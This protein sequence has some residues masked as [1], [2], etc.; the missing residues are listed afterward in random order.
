MKLLIKYGKRLAWTILSLIICLAIITTLYYFNIISSN[1]FKILQI[2]TLLIIILINSFIL[3]KSSDKKGFLEGIKFGGLLVI[4]FFILSLITKSPLKL[5][6][7]LYD[8]IIIIT[9][10]LGATI[11]INKRLE[12]SSR[13][14]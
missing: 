9:S 14:N 13:E 1:T 10:I 3:G 8:L 4:L 5:K 12:K 11:G 2:I 7:L 6:F